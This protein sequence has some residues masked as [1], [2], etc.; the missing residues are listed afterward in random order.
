M[1]SELNLILKGTSRAFYLS[2]AALP[3]G[4][5]YPLSLGYLLARAADTIADSPASPDLDR[6]RVLHELRQ[7][8]LDER[9]RDWH[10][11]R[12]LE[13]E[14]PKERELLDSIPRLLKLLHTTPSEQSEAVRQVVST[15]IEGMLWDQATFS[16]ESAENRTG[17]SAEQLEIYTYLV[18]GCVGPFWSKICALSEPALKHMADPRI[19]EMAIEFGKGLQWVNILRDAPKDQ[20]LGRYYLAALGT[21]EFL[22]K[23]PTQVE[24]A[25]QALSTA[26]NYPVL[27]PTSALRHRLAVFWPLALGF[28]TLELLLQDGGPRP[29]RRVK[30]ARW[31]VLGWIAMGPLIV[32]SNLGLK[33]V[34]GHLKR[35][36]EQARVMLE[37]RL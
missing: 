25:L 21:P 33:F 16:P 1:D 37:E 8:I 11:P 31:E 29:D 24:R 13:P 35:R 4:A 27:F 22:K 32:A 9:E 5:R 20:K 23:F 3:S 14:I 30:V 26:S 18:A 36:A 10:V 15:L 7:V 28:R 6:D 17:L 12:G 19:G 34:L 2:L